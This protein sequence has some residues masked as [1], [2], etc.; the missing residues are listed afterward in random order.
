MDHTDAPYSRQIRPLELGAHKRQ[1]L[2]VRHDEKG[3]NVPGGRQG[4]RD[5]GYAPHR[6][7]TDGGGGDAA[8]PGRPYPWKAKYANRTTR[9]AGAAIK[10]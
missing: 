10:R 7:C 5:G 3:P 8:R 2:D 1:L 4:A 6:M 9:D